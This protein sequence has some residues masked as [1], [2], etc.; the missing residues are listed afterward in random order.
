[1]G[2]K[3]HPGMIMICCSPFFALC[4]ADHIIEHNTDRWK[5][6]YIVVNEDDPGRCNQSNGNAF[7]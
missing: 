7:H 1:M 2:D 6:K 3:L 5:H 4:L